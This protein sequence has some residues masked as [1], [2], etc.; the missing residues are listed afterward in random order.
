M[1]LKKFSKF[2][3]GRN[4]GYSTS[5][6]FYCDYG[7]KSISRGNINGAQIESA[8]K[9]FSKKIKKNGKIIIRIHPNINLTKKPIEVRMGSGKGEIYSKIYKVRPGTI[10]FEINYNGNINKL[11]YLASRKLPIKTCIFYKKKLKNL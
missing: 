3:K 6:L 2:R 1:N 5:K 7:L 9:I 11:F 4:K 8:R 10:L